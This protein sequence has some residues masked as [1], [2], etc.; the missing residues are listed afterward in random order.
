MRVHPSVPVR[1][2]MHAEHS[3]VAA[4]TFPAATQQH[5]GVTG[6]GV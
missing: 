6:E 2:T 5:M 1:R 4:G 3:A